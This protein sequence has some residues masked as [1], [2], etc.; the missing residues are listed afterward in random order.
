MEDR[1]QH[2]RGVALA[3]FNGDGKTDIVYG[4]WNGPHRLYLQTSDFRFRVSRKGTTFGKIFKIFAY[5]KN[6]RISVFFEDR[7]LP[8]EILLL[9]PLSAPSSLQTSIMTRSWRCSLTTLPTEEMHQTD[10]SGCISRF[11]EIRCI[12]HT[13][14]ATRRQSEAFLKFLYFKLVVFS[15]LWL[16]AGCQEELMQTLRSM[17]LTW[18]MLR[19]RR[20]EEQVGCLGF[21]I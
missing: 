14:L 19:S 12:S 8:V 1:T 3:D 21:Q 7:M 9:R 11:S 16:P 20:G 10:C 4:N 15:S 18:E 2:G 5:M 6:M 17:S 13:Y